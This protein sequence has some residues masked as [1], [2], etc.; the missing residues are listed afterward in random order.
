[1]NTYPFIKQLS[2]T[3]NASYFLMFIFIYIFKILFDCI[4]H[5]ETKLV[6]TWGVSPQHFKLF[7]DKPL[8]DSDV[9]VCLNANFLINEELEQSTFQ[10]H[11]NF[12]C[13]L[14]IITLA[15]LHPQNV[16]Y[17]CI[18][19]KKS[20]LG[21]YFCYW[22]NIKIEIQKAHRSTVLI[23]VLLHIINCSFFGIELFIGWVLQ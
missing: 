8:S 10:F 3:I 17:L 23:F 14:L 2:G 15:G 20:N 19:K 5:I 1:M 21:V 7:K 11:V 16:Y 4:S 6:S 9:F 22:K 18:S 13:F 12:I